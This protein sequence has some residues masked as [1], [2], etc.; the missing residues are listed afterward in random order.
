MTLSQQEKELAA[1]INFDE[2]VFEIIKKECSAEIQKLH[3]VEEVFFKDEEISNLNEVLPEHYLDFY[4]DDYGGSIVVEG[5]S[6]IVYAEE[7]RQ[8]FFRLKHLLAM[9]GYTIY[10]DGRIDLTQKSLIGNICFKSIIKLFK[11]K[12]RIEI[13]RCKDK[14]NI[15]KTKQTNGWNYD[16]STKDIINKFKKWQEISNFEII[17]ASNSSLLLQFTGFPKDLEDF[18]RE[19]YELCP[20]VQDPKKVIKEITKYKCLYLSWD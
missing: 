18:A 8:T 7:P 19:V 4:H 3:L 6:V 10:S 13:F 17:F 20:D 12:L 2:E 5:L 14:L 11:L 16:V 1:E 9:K 15:I